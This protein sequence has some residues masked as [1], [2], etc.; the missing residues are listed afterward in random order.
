MTIDVNEVLEILTVSVLPSGTVGRYYSA[1]YLA[2]GGGGSDES[3]Q[4][5]A[6]ALPDGLQLKSLAWNISGIPTE[7]GTF[8]FTLTLR[9]GGQTATKDF[10]VTIH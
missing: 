7:A 2:K 6:G 8:N 10:S 1:V 5:T 9:S 4:I 3:W